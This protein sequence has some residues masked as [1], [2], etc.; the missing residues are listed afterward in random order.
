MNSKMI[1]TILKAFFEHKISSEILSA[2][3]NKQIKK[4]Y[5]N[6]PQTNTS[7]MEA[8]NLFEIETK[9]IAFIL[10]ETLKGKLTFE[11]LNKIASGLLFS[12]LFYWDSE[13]E[14]GERIAKIIFELDTPEI[15]FPIINRNLILWKIYLETGIHS[16]K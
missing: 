9:H 16:L 14:T 6:T 1:D 5:Y 15:C 10:T 11:D 8:N 13:T 4:H 7:E 12:D 2:E 3:L